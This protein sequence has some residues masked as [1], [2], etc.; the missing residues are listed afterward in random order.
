M[1]G[2]GYREITVIFIL[3][4]FI[5]HSTRFFSFLHCLLYFV[6]FRV[7]F[8]VRLKKHFV[9]PRVRGTITSKYK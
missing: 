1:V 3:H 9:V 8:I 4:S 7:R 6:S 2:G 5:L